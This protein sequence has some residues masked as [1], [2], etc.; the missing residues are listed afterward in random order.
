MSSE[1]RA[2]AF[3]PAPAA[4]QPALRKENATTLALALG[5]AHPDDAAALCLAFLETMETGGPLIGNPYGMPAADARLWADI[6]PVHEL[7]AYGVAALDSLRSAA[8][9][10]STRKRLFADIWETFDRDDR[11]AFLAKVDPEGRFLRRG[12]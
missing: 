7:V 12:D 3:T 4:D 11:I 2:S 9:G 10:V 1:Y 5:E 8:L 6:A